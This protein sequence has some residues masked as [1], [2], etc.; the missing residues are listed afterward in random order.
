VEKGELPPIAERLP[1]TPSIVDFRAPDAAGQYGGDLTIL[2]SRAKDVRMMVVYGYSRLV[3]WTPD[4]RLVPDIAEKVTV[5]DGRQF[6]FVLREGHRWSDGE[7]FT[8]EDF[9]YWW[10]DIANNRELSPMGPPAELLVRGK[11]PT[12]EVIDDRTVRY[13]WDEP[14]PDFLPALAGAAPLYIYAPAHYLKRFHEKYA[15]PTLLAERV[16]RAGQRNWAALHNRRDAMYRNDNPALPT[17]EPWIVQTRPPSQRFLFVRNPY[18]YRIDRNGR[19]LPYIDRVIINIADPKIVPAK[20]AAG[21][22][23]LQARGLHFNDYTFLKRG[24]K[25][26]GYR[27]LLWRT[28]KGSQVAIYPNLNVSDPVWQRLFRDVR[29]RRALSLAINRHEINQVVYFGLGAEG[30]DTALSGSPLYRPEYQ[31][32]WATFDLAQANALLDQIGLTKRDDRGVRLLPDGRPAELIVETA[33][34]DTEQSDVLELIYDS[35]LA[36]GIKLHIRP[37]QRELFRNRIFS[38]ET[39]MSVWNGLENGLPTPAMSPAEL[40]PTTQQQLQWPKWGQ[41]FETDGKVGEGPDDPQAIEL[42]KLYR[43]W[44]AATADGARAAIWHRMLKIWS[45]QVYSIGTVAGVPQPVVVGD[46][47]RNVPTKG[48]Y[49]WEPGAFFGIYRPDTFWYGAPA[50][51]GAAPSNPAARAAR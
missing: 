51:A 25:A 1:A 16:A 6:T 7:P 5:K 9:R 37:S 30:A 31:N 42:L 8:T 33:G 44:R 39:M 12:F 3:A 47:L 38:G 23:A 2:M 29:F 13:A 49:N 24:E 28:T 48:V 4:F 14:N 19:Q 43:Q 26:H 21:E 10:E 32:A 27:V 20:T 46:R 18:Y 45:D 15:D 11:L 34:E 35:W 50:P 41:F 36:A 40:A 17:L 22:A